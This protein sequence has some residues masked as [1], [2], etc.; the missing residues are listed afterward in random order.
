ME[1]RFIDNGT[2]LDV[3][4]A[5]DGSRSYGDEIYPGKLVSMEDNL[6]FTMECGALNQLPRELTQG[7]YLKFTFYR[8]AEVYTF[9]GKVNGSV[10]KYDDRVLV[11]AVTPLERSSRRKSQRILINIPVNVYKKDPN[12]PNG[13]GNLVCMGTSFDISN[14]GICVLSDEKLDLRDGTRFIAE[15]SLHRE[16]TFFLTVIHIRTGNSPNLIQFKHDHAFLFDEESEA[17]KI[18]KMI[19]SLFQYKLE[20]RL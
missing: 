6:S 7:S 5:S 16:E 18:N 20:N 1:L 14:T 4:A 19:L 15:F 2:R 3:Q 10:S 11:T 12:Q 8:G 13:I 9:E 17:E